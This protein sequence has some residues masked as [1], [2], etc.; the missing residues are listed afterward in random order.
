MNENYNYPYDED[1]EIDLID[2]MFYLLKQWRTLIVAILIGAILGGGI[3]AVKKNSANKAAEALEAEMD[4][5]E[6]DVG[7]EQTVAE[8]KEKYQISEDVE[9]NM[10]L[11]YQYRQLYR[12]QL[13]Y[14][15]NSPIMQMNPSAVYFGELEYYVSA[16]YDTGVVALLYQNIL[17]G[18]DILAELKDAAALDYKEQYIRELIGCSVSRENDSTINVNSGE[19]LIYKNA[20]V[21]FTVNAAT[22]ESCEEMLQ[23]IR[24]KVSVID[25]DCRESY[26]D[27][28]MVAVSD[29]VNLV[30]SSEYLSRQKSNIDQLNSYRNT[31]TTLES[32]FTEDELVYYNKIYL[33]RDYNIIEEEE[34]NA[35]AAVADAV[36]QVEQVSLV[37]WL[38]IGIFLM[39]IV[40]VGLYFVKYLLDKRIKTPDEMRSRYRL[41]IIGFVKTETGVPKSL[42]GWLDRI[43]SKGWGTDERTENIG[44][45]IDAMDMTKLLF[46]MESNGQKLEVVVDEICNYSKNLRKTEA[47]QQNGELV[48]EAKESDG[49]ILAVEIGN[50]TYGE[51]ER[52]LEICRMQKITVKGVI[53]VA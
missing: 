24:E 7:D 8:L 31:M 15:Q 21:T 29:S 9:T 26:E 47:L 10:E 25:Q 3:Y 39:C 14:N 20:I 27:Y 38:V 4:N 33:S 44:S 51:I 46:C 5:A 11:A 43:R 12:K 23:V 41:P 50:T 40:W 13:E 35:D 32:S 16:G 28:N 42:D 36:V 37:K 1:V 48:A 2:L 30:S 22:E 49:I 53:V 6:A 34:G 45:M 52:E 19:S 18:R 17:N